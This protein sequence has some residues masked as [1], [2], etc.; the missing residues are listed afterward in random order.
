MQKVENGG[1]LTPSEPDNIVQNDYMI[2]AH[3]VSSNKIPELNYGWTNICT[4]KKR[5]SAL[6]L[7]YIKRGV[8]APDITFTTGSTKETVVRVMRI[9]GADQITFIDAS[10]CT[11]DPD[12]YDFGTDAPSVTTTQDNDLILRFGTSKRNEMDGWAT[13][14]EDYDVGPTGHTQIRGNELQV[15]TGATGTEFADQHNAF[16]GDVHTATVAIRGK[17]TANN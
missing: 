8:S 5:G 15:T 16:T 7:Q 4:A 10:A 2:A 13:L 3:S 14:T 6:R 11:S 1:D 9:S 12:F 17:S